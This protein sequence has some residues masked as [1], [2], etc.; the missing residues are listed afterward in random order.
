M[1]LYIV[2]HGQTIWNK[3][4]RIQ[5]DSDI[6]LTERGRWM[7]AQ[8]AQGLQGVHFDAIY[9][10]PLSRSYDTAC[11]IRGNRDLSVVKDSRLREMGF[12]VIEGKSFDDP[13]SGAAQFFD[14]FYHDPL[15]YQPPEGGET[16]S[17]LCQ[18]ADDFIADMVAKYTGDE[19]VLI[20]AHQALN[21]ALLRCIKGLPLE[22][23][24]E[25]E[26]LRFCSLCV[27]EYKNGAFE[28]LQEDTV[29]Y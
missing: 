6:M 9:S 29:F 18:R 13:E 1:K 24:W 17:S 7:A 5:G 25:G 14:V 20:V 26:F 23:F 11:I 21:K 2:R 3:E 16:F 10:S 8:T 12:G 27:A 22:K 28:M 15:A 4:R 19:H